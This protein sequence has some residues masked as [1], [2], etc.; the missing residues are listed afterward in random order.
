MCVG[1]RIQECTEHRGLGM[2]KGGVT[3]CDAEKGHADGGEAGAMAPLTT[4]WR[5]RDLCQ[6]FAPINAV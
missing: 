1:R 4:L 2:V 5:L 6:R 3:V